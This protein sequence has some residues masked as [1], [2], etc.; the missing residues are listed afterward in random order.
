MAVIEFVN[1]SDKP[2]YHLEHFIDGDY[3]KYNSN[4]GFVEESL[5]LTPQVPNIRLP[6]IMRHT[7]KPYP[8]LQFHVGLHLAFY[9]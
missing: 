8:T 1:R 7:I 4:S 2:L 5:R 9:Q 3:I 6:D